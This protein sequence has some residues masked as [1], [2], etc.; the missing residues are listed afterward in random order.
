MASILASR[1]ARSSSSSASSSDGFAALLGESLHALR[2]DCPE[3]YREAVRRLDGAPVRVEVGGERV[4]VRGAGGA[5]EI[6][7]AAFDPAA[8]TLVTRPDVLVALL[9]GE[10]RLLDC[11]LD[12][13]LVLAGPVPVLLRLHEALVWY[14][15]GAVRSAAFPGLLHRLRAWSRGQ[16]GSHAL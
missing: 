4:L 8:A 2:R 6:D 12:D 7:E 10:A 15:R 5:H 16:E 3:A 14:L 1:G 11:L 13:R 9:D